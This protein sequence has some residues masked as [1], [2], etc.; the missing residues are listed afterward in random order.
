M[1]M[2]TKPTVND[3]R[4][5]VDELRGALALIICWASETEKTRGVEMSDIRLLAIDS[6]I[7]S[8]KNY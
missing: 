3:L 7:R 8:K 4:R 6:L 2:N 5:E 1:S